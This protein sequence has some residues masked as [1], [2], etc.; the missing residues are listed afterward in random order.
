[1]LKEIEIPE[2]QNNSGGW[3][4][5]KRERS[6]IKRIAKE[7][8]LPQSIVRR[9]IILSYKSANFVVE[10]RS[11]SKDRRF[12]RMMNVILPG[13]GILMPHS[14]MNTI[15]DYIDGYDHQKA[16]RAVKDEKALKYNAD[17]AWRKTIE[18]KT[19]EYWERVNG[20]NL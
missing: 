8:K 4:I 17:K 12:I 9:C 5:G 16:I 7:Q 11:V 15:W 6:I 1:M 20:G 18:Q 3:Y 14:L 19:I 13:I 2:H 10:H